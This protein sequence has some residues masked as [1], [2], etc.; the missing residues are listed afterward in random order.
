MRTPRRPFGRVRDLDVVDADPSIGGQR[1][2]LGQD[3]GAVRDRDPQLGQM[4]GPDGT[5]RKVPPSRA[6][7]L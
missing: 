1:S 3:T 2:D 6:G 7:L 5:S 4:V